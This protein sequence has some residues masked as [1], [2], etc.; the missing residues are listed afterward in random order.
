MDSESI[1]AW[2]K[3]RNGRLFAKWHATEDIELPG[4]KRK[5]LTLL[6]LG[7]LASHILTEVRPWPANLDLDIRHIPDPPVKAWWE[8]PKPEE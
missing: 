2:I 4:R 5:P 1:E 6:M 3:S 8:L 7:R